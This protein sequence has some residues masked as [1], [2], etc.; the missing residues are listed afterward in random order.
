MKDQGKK[1]GA[2][3]GL[4]QVQGMSKDR[5][6]AAGVDSQAGDLRAGGETGPEQQQGQKK[7]QMQGSSAD[8]D[9]S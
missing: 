1:A 7:T 4:G 9:A 8:A 5:S 2:G 6:K 3:A